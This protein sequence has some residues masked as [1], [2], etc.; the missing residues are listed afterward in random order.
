MDKFLKELREKSKKLVDVAGLDNA[1]SEAKKL[2]KNIKRKTLL[3]S[4]IK[5]LKVF[6]SEE[7]FTAIK[8]MIEHDN[9]IIATASTPTAT[10]K[11]DPMAALQQKYNRAPA[12]TANSSVDINSLNFFD[13]YEEIK[14]QEVLYTK[15]PDYIFTDEA[16]LAKYKELLTSINQLQSKVSV[17]ASKHGQTP[18]FNSALTARNNDIKDYSDIISL[19]K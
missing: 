4:A 7:N 14:A 10:A 3:K 2:L 8:S 19:I 11:K 9:R 15:Y 16:D 5:E 6:Y 18:A 1:V 12:T 17:Y 13:L